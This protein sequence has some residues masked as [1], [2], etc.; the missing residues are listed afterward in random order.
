M[1]YSLE[2]GRGRL[3]LL[4]FW[5]AD[6][7]WAERAD[8]ELAGCLA[9]WGDRVRLWSIASNAN[10]PVSQIEQAAAARG[11]PLVLL[12]EGNLVADLYGAQA[13]PYFCLIDA[14]GV[15]RY[16][17]AFDDVTFRRRSP[18]RYYL[19]EAVEALLAGRLPDPAFTP[20]YGC[21]IVRQAR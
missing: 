1:L 18:E 19:R 4:N 15:L 8:R 6:C 11:L 16:Q 9:E 13:T 2:N 21:T 3:V 10:E 7:P 17:G 14:A 12:D 20:A 5:S